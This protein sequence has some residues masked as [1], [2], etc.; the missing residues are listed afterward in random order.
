[1][2]RHWERQHRFDARPL[3][4]AEH[5]SRFDDGKARFEDHIIGRINQRHRAPTVANMSLNEHI[6]RIDD[7]LSLRL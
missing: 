1:M 6:N 4:I 2:H 3:V 7:A 5:A